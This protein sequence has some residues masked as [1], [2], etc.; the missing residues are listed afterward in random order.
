MFTPNG[1]GY[2]VS[3]AGAF[4]L[5]AATV[6]GD[7]AESTPAGIRNARTM[8]DAVLSAARAGGYTQ[9]DVLHTLLARNKVDRRTME[10]AQAACDA[11][12][13]AR[14]A[15]VMRNAGLGKGGVQ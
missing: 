9:G 3:P 12:G 1:D 11:A 8:L 5:C 7:P 4:V 14:M 2:D 6:Y 13:A 15:V 10:M